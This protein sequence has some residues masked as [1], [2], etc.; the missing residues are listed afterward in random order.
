MDPAWRDGSRLALR[1]ALAHHPLC[2][3][4]GTHTLRLGGLA[5]CAGC[6]AT[7]PA[8]LVGVLLAAPTAAQA[9]L[10]WLAAGLALGLPYLAAC[11]L[12]PDRRVRTAAKMVGGA[13]LGMALL[14][15]ALA[16]WP[17]V[18]KAALMALP[19]AAF[20][21]LQALRWRAMRQV[22]AACPWQGDWARCPGF[23]PEATGS[24]GRARP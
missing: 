4:F 18:V 20:L 15:G 23:S 7:L 12:R 3:W 1:L 24:A 11:L 13:G 8:V 22:C 6:A 14:A 17:P 9:P 2:G 19:V 21:G 5:V 10:P 16:P